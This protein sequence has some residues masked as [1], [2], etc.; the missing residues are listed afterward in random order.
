MTSETMAVAPHRGRPFAPSH[1][2]DRNWFLLLILLTWAGVLVGFGWDVV[3]HVR[4]HGPPFPIIVHIHAA[5]FVGWLALLTVQSLLVRN[6]R[7]DLHRK[8]GWAMLGLAVL[9]TPLGLAAGWVS[10]RR[11]HGTPFFDPAFFIFQIDDMVGFTGLVAAAFWLRA[12]PAAHKRLMV[13]AT[14]FISIAGFSRIWAFAVP[15]A[16][17]H[18]FSSFFVGLNTGSDV[19]ILAIGAFDLITRGRLAPAYGP[20]LIWVLANEAAASWLYFSPAWKVLATRIA[21]Y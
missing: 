5:V 11:A 6:R 8:L 15:G 1:P 19:L 18:H 12:Q 9:M 20:A 14:L 10:E 21:G 3:D 13:I 17:S 4:R 7:M 16:F 2:W